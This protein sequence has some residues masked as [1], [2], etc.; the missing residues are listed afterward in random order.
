[1]TW[2]WC[3][4]V[5]HS[6]QRRLMVATGVEAGRHTA[7][8]AQLSKYSA[9]HHKFP[10]RGMVEC[11]LSAAAHLQSDIRDQ[12]LPVQLGSCS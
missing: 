3:R 5:F 7:V 6:T 12:A 1:M 10:G 11:L 9:A 2:Q 4:T 8:C